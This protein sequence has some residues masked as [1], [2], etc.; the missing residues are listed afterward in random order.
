M[1]RCGGGFGRRLMNDYMVEAAWISKQ[2]G[3]PVKLLWN[4]P[5]DIQ[6]DFYRP[7]GFHFF[8]AGLDADGKVKAFR[9]HF[10]ERAPAHGFG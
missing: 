2:V 4:R 3:A 6:H 8:K 7:A 10:I 9:D 1:T 5:D